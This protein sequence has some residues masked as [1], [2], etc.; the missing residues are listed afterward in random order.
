MPILLYLVYYIVHSNYS[1]NA[2]GIRSDILSKLISIPNKLV[3]LLDNIR[4]ELTPEGEDLVPPSRAIKQ[5]AIEAG[6]LKK[7][8]RKTR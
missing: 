8:K 7:H 5:L 3:I 6:R 2:L 4:E 1:M